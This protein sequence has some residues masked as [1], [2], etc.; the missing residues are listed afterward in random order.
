MPEAA[1][2]MSDFQ[3][4]IEAR[5]LFITLDRPQTRNAL[6]GDMCAAITQC[7]RDHEHEVAVVVI[8]GAGS[9]FCAGADLGTRFGA[10]SEDG[11]ATDTFRPNFEVLLDTIADY[12]VPVIAAING[13]AIGAGMQLA[14]AC[15]IR[16]AT[17]AA[18]LAIP[19]G[20]L[21][22]L[23][24]P[25]NVWR[26]AHLVG[27]GLAR[28][29]LLTG[30][31]VDGLEAGG[32]G[33]VQ[34]VADDPQTAAH[35]LATQIAALAPLTVR[36]HKRVLNLVADQTGLSKKRRNVAQQLEAQAFASKDLIEGTAAF[37]EKRAPRFTGE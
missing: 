35:E 31:M 24:S 29:F 36:G 34:R 28:D 11:P 1:A 13:P 8:T 3:V 9:A 7:L 15:D 17:P 30:R 19:G 12:P 23:L 37:A 26:L 6:S 10:G 5:I 33:L 20:K 32:L 21:G 22:I 2:D 18:K 27:H 16:I 4:S 14:V 25:K